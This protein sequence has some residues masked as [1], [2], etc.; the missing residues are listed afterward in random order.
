[1]L[2]YSLGKRTPTFAMR[3]D[4]L[5]TAGELAEA[6][7][8]QKIITA[9]GHFYAKYFSESLGLD[10]TGGYVRI[11]FVHYNTVEEVDKVTKILGEISAKNSK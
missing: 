11:G 7:V 1:M 6:L 2:H 4:S 9:S 5:A 8:D 10:K 3:M